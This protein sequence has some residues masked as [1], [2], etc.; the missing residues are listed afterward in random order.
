MKKATDRQLSIRFSPELYAWIDAQAK[1]NKRS[2][3]A[4]V[5]LLLE[6]LQQPQEKGKK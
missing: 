3:N 6:R 4:Q 2:F 5:V 1:E